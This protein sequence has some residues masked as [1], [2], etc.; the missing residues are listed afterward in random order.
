MSND[1]SIQDIR[2]RLGP[3][4]AILAHHYQGGNVV[5]HADR[6]GDSLELAKIGASLD[7]KNIVVCGVTFMAET[8]SILRKPDQSV[9]IPEKRAGCVM[10]DMADPALF[11][12]I[13]LE[14]LRRSGRRIIPLAYVNTSAEI[15]ALVGE[16]GGSLCTSANARKMME[17][18]LAQGDAVL[19]L[20][21]RN[22][23]HNT[24]DTLGL[25]D[26]DRH[27][28]N[29][30]LNGSYVDY[31]ACAKARLIVWPGFCPVHDRFDVRQVWAMREEYPDVRVVVHPEC[32]PDVVAESDAMGST[33]FIIKYVAEAKPGSTIAVGTEI[34]LVRRLMAQYQDK[35]VTVVPLHAS[36]CFNMTRV[37]EDKLLH[38]LQSI[39][40]VDPV[41]LPDKTVAG[42]TLAFERMFNA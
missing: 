13:L 21:D 7:A 37:T 6:V 23:G 3:D 5:E 28:L 9:F 32:T 19:F 16:H 18:A 36:S 15:K 26:E 25:P 38:L 14:M 31:D 33:S 40:S 12:D 35:G 30:K 24:A 22:L 29:V 41:V 2:E 42:A 1:E 17:W 20:P 8:A 4:L 39:E 10:A 11:E 34:H 27:D